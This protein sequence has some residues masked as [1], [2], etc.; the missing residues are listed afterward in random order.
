MVGAYYP[1]T[2]EE[3]LKIRSERM[4]VPYAGGTDLMVQKNHEHPFLFLS[5]IKELTGI[6]LE[7]D[8]LIIGS[9]TSYA[10][11]LKDGRIPEVLKEAIQ[12][13][14]APAIR[15]L[16]TIGGN[17]CNASPAGDTLPVLYAMDA[18]LILESAQAVQATQAVQAVQAVQAEQTAQTLQT[19]QLSQS[20]RIEDFITG[21]KKTRLESTQLLT[22]IIIP[23]KDREHTYYKV[24]A[25]KAQAISK[26]S[27]AGI[28][29]V[30]EGVIQEIGIA[31]GA[32]GPMVVRSREIEEKIKGRHKTELDIDEILSEY[33]RLIKPIDDQRSTAR[34]RKQICLNILHEYLTAGL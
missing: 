24:G 34:Y 30:Q 32:V 10:D 7:G 18:V 5:A 2:L 3:A 16:G 21:V 23:I 12:G 31:F 15:N 17:I 11:L 33:G 6:Q 22:K 19:P 27:F 25:R 26:L 1:E 29:R 14:A 9:A 20:V 28:H 13:I 4:V 8:K